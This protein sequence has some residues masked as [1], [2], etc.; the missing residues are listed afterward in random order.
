M[1]LSLIGYLF[2][3][4]HWRYMQIGLVIFSAYSLVEWWYVRNNYNRTMYFKQLVEN[5]YHAKGIEQG[6]S[7]TKK[8]TPYHCYH[9][10]LVSQ[11]I[12]ILC[13]ALFNQRTLQP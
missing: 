3:D 6:P 11:Y 7:Y 1:V 10:W 9:S 8:L 5:T 13:D 2:R 12:V 4:I